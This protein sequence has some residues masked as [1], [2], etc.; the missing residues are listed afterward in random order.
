M[1]QK[2]AMTLF[3]IVV[4]LGLV[5]SAFLIV[6]SAIPVGQRLQEKA[7]FQLYA[8]AKAVDLISSFNTLAPNDVRVAVTSNIGPWEAHANYRPSTFDLEQR[9]SNQVNGLIPLPL[10]IARRLDSD[11]DEIQRLL[12]AGGKLFYPSPK[13][14]T[15]LSNYQSNPIPPSEA[16]RMIVGIVGD[17]QSGQVPSFPNRQWPQYSPYPG[18]PNTGM[19][20]NAHFTALDPLLITVEGRTDWGDHPNSTTDLNPAIVTVPTQSGDKGLENFGS[21]T[22]AGAY[23]YSPSARQ[24]WTQPTRERALRYFALAYWYADEKALPALWL[25]GGRATPADV[26]QFLNQDPVVRALQTTAIRI[27]AHAAMILTRY[28]LATTLET[29]GVL[30]PTF[31]FVTTPSG[32]TRPLPSGK[33]VTLDMIRNWHENCLDV[34]MAYASRYPYDW[35]APRPYNRPLAWDS[36]L[37]QWDLWPGNTAEKCL[38]QITFSEAAPGAAGAV[39]AEQWKV[40]T[41]QP[42]ENGI[43]PDMPSFSMVGSAAA[44][45]TRFNLTNR[46]EPSERCRQL[47]FW[48]VD[49]QSYED[50]E[51]APS[52][53]VDSSRYFLNKPGNPGDPNRWLQRME[54]AK[55][56]NPDGKSAERPSYRNPERKLLFLD[57]PENYMI[58]HYPKITV[59]PGESIFM[60][61]YIFGEEKRFDSWWNWSIPDCGNGDPTRRCN[62]PIKSNGTVDVRTGTSGSIFSGLCGADRNGNGQFDRGLRPSTQRLRAT[63]IARFIVYDPRLPLR[64]R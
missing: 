49:W 2:S 8:S 22:A 41:P 57:R 7:R 50:F 45:A 29:T 20:F 37:L 18:P 39:S 15:S 62:T 42:I 24:G 63:T 54:G 28:D 53:P 46:F 44:T 19:G 59:D 23:W 52:S 12:A 1:I 4:S 64:L 30:I 11:N 34:A 26:D 9:L 51:S 60:G 40:L 27:L 48:A 43:C 38:G 5:A 21:D 6:I 3:E 56:I 16:R 10:E 33:W 31:T 17:A 36:P 35:G 14:T 32:A 58:G 61:D 13:P 25:D 55:N 47:V